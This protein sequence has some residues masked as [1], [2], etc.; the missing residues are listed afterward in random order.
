M[1]VAPGYGLACDPADPRSIAAAIG[2]LFEHPDEMRAMGEAGRRRIL[3]EW[4]YENTFRP[5]FDCL[6][7]PAGNSRVVRQVRPSL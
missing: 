6:S 4:N 1:F 7:L 2:W 5:V 3:A